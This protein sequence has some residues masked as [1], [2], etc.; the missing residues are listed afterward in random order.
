MADDFGVDIIR[1]RCVGISMSQSVA[2]WKWAPRGTTG[3]STGIK[4]KAKSGARVRQRAISR[5]A[6]ASLRRR[7]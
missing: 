4:L 2:E 1:Q 6:V 7:M 5:A 3:G